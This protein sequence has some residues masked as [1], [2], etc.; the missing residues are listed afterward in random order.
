MVIFRPSTAWALGAIVDS[1]IG[2]GR[3]GSTHFGGEPFKTSSLSVRERGV[4][5]W[6]ASRMRWGTHALLMVTSMLGLSL[7]HLD[8]DQLQLQLASSIIASP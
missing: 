4:P 8:V 5:L 2:P 7:S 3:S 6:K 1:E